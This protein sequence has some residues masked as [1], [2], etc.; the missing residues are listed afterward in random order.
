MYLKPPTASLNKSELK[1]EGL[2]V[3]RLKRTGKKSATKKGKKS[4]RKAGKK[5]AKK[6]KGKT[7]K[8][9]QA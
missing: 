3:P 5:P 6:S 1:M 8:M 4:T 7:Y 2:P 9:I